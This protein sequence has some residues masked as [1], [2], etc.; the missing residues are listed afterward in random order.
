MLIEHLVQAA[1]LLLHQIHLLLLAGQRDVERFQ[2]IILPGQ[3]DFQ[4]GE[5]VFGVHCSPGEIESLTK[6]S[7]ACQRV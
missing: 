4:F 5:A 1:Q 6:P 3:A 2:Q 7:A